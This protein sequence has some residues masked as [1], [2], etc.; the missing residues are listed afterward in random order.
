MGN[1]QKCHGLIVYTC[2]EFYHNTT[3]TKVKYVLFKLTNKYN[4]N[5]IYY[6]KPKLEFFLLKKKCG[7]KICF[8]KKLQFSH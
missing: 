1:S 7:L 8:S 2:K 5:L 4:L 3:S 6:L